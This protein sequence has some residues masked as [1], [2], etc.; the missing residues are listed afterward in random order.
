MS[1]PEGIA[2]T[3]AEQVQF[4]LRYLKFLTHFMRL[5]MLRSIFYTVSLEFEN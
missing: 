4:S 2:A 3:A 5:K 1:V